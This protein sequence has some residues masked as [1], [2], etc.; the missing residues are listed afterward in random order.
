MKIAACSLLIAG[1]ALVPA[2]ADE[3]EDA[4]WGDIEVGYRSVTVDGNEDKYREDV[5]LP[6][7]AIRLFHFDVGWRPEASG[8]LDELSLE[9]HGLG[10]EPYESAR[11][12]AR[13]VG[14]WDLKAAYRSSQFFYRDAGYFFREEGDLHSW[15]AERTF[16]D[17][18][19]RV[20]AAD[21]L[22]LRTGADRK[23]RDGR[24][25]T[26]RNLQ[27]DLFL[28]HRPVDQTASTYWLGADLRLGWADVTLEQRLATHENRWVLTGD[29]SEG[30]ETGGAVIEDYRQTHDQEADTPITRVLLAGVPT[31]WLR[32]SVGYLRAD[33][34]LDYRVDGAW[35]GL[36]YDD[37][38]DGNPPEDYATSLANGGKV[39]R[40]ADVLT[41]DVSFRPTPSLEFTLEGSR[42]SYDQ[43]GT[44]DWVEEQTGGK[45]S[46]T[47]R[48]AGSLR[49]ELDVDALG[50][51]GRWES[52]FGLSLSA[53]VGAE[54]RT[55][56]FEISG[57]DVTTERTYYRGDL[58]Y[59]LRDR[60][61]IEA[62]Y[63]SGSDNDPY[64]PAS[65]TKIERLR[66]Q[67]SVRPGGGTR[68]AARFREETRENDLTYPLGRAT[69]DTPPATSYGGA[70]L[71]LT[72]WGATFGWERGEWLDL[73]LGYDR[74][75]LRSDADLV[76]VTGFTFV[77]AFDV[78]TTLDP[79]AYVSD[80]DALHGRARFT[81]GAGVSL[82]ATASLVSNDGTF[83][84]DWN[85]YGAEA[86]WQH[87]SGFYS[88]L[89]FDRYELDE[90]NP[91][92]G[93]PD[94][95]SPD[96]NDYDADLWTLAVGY[97]F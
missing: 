85:V 54:E 35:S 86:R 96:V 89:A 33:T 15:D 56:S 61:R 60:F 97:R 78:F 12:R 46:G 70:R 37:T 48:V 91:Y 40:M 63:E 45:E 95:P 93:D 19:L 55:A 43:D 27:R 16:Y 67:V 8:A 52:S 59:R 84:V 83:P 81:V 64:A 79:T 2:I 9:A 34:E 87:G 31:E 22:T 68:L 42:R 17:I 58:R 7:D 4:W 44:I 10:G 72:A 5:N 71:D 25:T 65:P 18:D 90:T 49:N 38:P 41:A 76:Y 74:I 26:S 53:G 50:V 6:E 36:D 32:F 14:R 24:S 11:F 29:P 88:R 66:A 77:P 75:E 13:K 51:T 82:L 80:Q 3:A 62:G 28:L 1:T 20:R 21:W 94:A 23:E 57:P 73:E 39:E 47:Y 92:A 69:D 30:E